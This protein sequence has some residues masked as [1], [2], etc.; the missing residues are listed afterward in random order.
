MGTTIKTALELEVADF[1]VPDKVTMVVPPRPKHEGPDFHG[2]DLPLAML[3]SYTLHTLCKNFTRRV[4]GIAKKDPL[5][6]AAPPQPQVVEFNSS[7]HQGRLKLR[8]IPG[9]EAE[10]LRAVLNGVLDSLERGAKDD[11]FG[12]D[13]DLDF[14]R[15]VLG[16][17]LDRQGY[18]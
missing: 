2:G 3:D 18:N 9:R 1:D 4:F 8:D 12:P 6:D 5:P 16:R 14:S 15:C 13:T 7:T 17:F 10:V 11:V